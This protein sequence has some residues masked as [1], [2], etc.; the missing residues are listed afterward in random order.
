MIF[1]KTILFIIS[2][3][4][5]STLAAQTPVIDS[6]EQVLASSK[7]DNL[8]KVKL[9]LTLADIY[10][11]SRD[12]EKSKNYATEALYMAQKNGWQLEEASALVTLGNVYIRE[13]QYYSGYVNF[14]KAEKIYLQ[15]NNDDKLFDLCNNLM[16][17]FNVILDD[18]NVI[19]YAEKLKEAAI[20]RGDKQSE[21]LARYFIVQ[22]RYNKN[23][24][25]IDDYIKMFQEALPLADNYTSFI[26]LNCGIE[27][28]D[29][30]KPREALYYL[31]WARDYY[32]KK[33]GNTTNLY[34]ILAET[35][36][37][38]QITDSAEYYIKKAFDDP[39]LP[40]VTRMT[41]Y[42]AQSLVAS[43]KNDNMSAL[44]FLKKH[45]SLQ[46]SRHKERKSADIAR[47]KNW[48]ELEQKDKEN[49]V[50]QQE[51]QKQYGLIRILTGAL[52]MIIV[53]LVLSV[54]LYRMTTEKNNELEQ[55]HAVKD[56][57]F[58]VVAH[59]LRSPMG[60]LMSLLNL[61]NDDMIDSE[62][63]AQLLKD[64][65]ARVD[66][67]YSLL[68]NLLHWSR[69]QMQG[70]VPAPVCFDAQEGSRAVT[71]SLQTI[72]ANKNIILNNRIQK[73]QIFADRDMFAV[74][75]RN[76]TMN[77]IKYTPE[78]GE[79]TLASELKDNM[80]I[81]SVKDNGTGMSKEVQDKL[82]KLSETRSKRGT[83][84]ESGTGLGLVLCADFVKINGGNIWF[85]SV[86]GEG[87]TF[88]FSVPLLLASLIP[89]NER[90]CGS[91][92]Q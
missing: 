80:L 9:L 49:E 13:E 91:S 18:D 82:F 5:Y 44:E 53:L 88:Y 4:L 73:Q 58:S 22:S 6:L 20:K 31:N 47:M 48:N 39:A 83:N 67:T 84:N 38:L 37:M 71:D 27:L 46:E 74:V 30:G 28:T 41:L 1:R 43:N 61:A 17:L 85:T 60:A 11:K 54:I 40:T 68:D 69:S 92:P 77:A 79:I 23:E 75:V 56:K 78:V 3:C 64:I 2:C 72:A 25:S 52:M 90:D 21:I 7:A 36:A 50:L 34:S 59:D 62:T 76:L 12:N 19:H 65:S 32:E 81:I 70:M 35:Y 29:A 26:A 45:H 63:Q 10:R 55:L 42:N 33:N 14:K 15:N 24:G 8:E 87:S 16:I 86:Q 51:R 57:L 89:K 66:D